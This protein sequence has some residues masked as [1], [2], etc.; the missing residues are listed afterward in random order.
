MKLQLKSRTSLALIAVGFI[1]LA[2]FLIGP[3]EPGVSLR[4]REAVLM[5]DLRTMRDA[6]DNYTLDKQRPPHSLQDPIT[7]KP[8]WVLDFEDPILGD[9]IVSPDLVGA[10]YIR[11]IPVDLKAKGFY[12]VH[13][14]SRRVASNGSQYNTW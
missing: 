2:L 11:A 10:G 6:I 8:D 1:A 12:D 13:S 3:R 5:T 4:T 7:H 9:P 14:N